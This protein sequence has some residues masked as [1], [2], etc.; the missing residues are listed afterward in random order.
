MFTTGDSE[1]RMVN[2][3]RNRNIAISSKSWRLRAKYSIF[4]NYPKSCR[5]WKKL[6]FRSLLYKTL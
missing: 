3:G 4:K 1:G 6:Q 2:K 5:Y